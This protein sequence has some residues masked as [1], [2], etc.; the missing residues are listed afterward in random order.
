MRRKNII[1]GVST[2]LCTALVLGLSACGG[3]ANTPQTIPAVNDTVKDTA[4]DGASDASREL[5]AVSEK[6]ASTKQI[7]DDRLIT[8]A[9]SLEDHFKG[10]D[11]VEYKVSIH[12][13][14]ILSED[15]QAQELNQRIMDIWGN[16]PKKTKDEYPYS[17]EQGITI[18]WETHWYGDLLSLVV[19]ED[20]PDVGSAYEVFY[21][22][23]A[24]QK[25]LESPDVLK[26]LSIQPEV[27]EKALLR[28]VAQSFDDYFKDSMVGAPEEVM[29]W[30]AKTLAS[31]KDSLQWLRFYPVSAD[32]LVV[33]ASHCLSS[34]EQWTEEKVDVLLN[35]KITPLHAESHYVTA[36]ASADG[37]TVCFHR[38]EYSDAFQEQYGFEYE[39]AYPVRGCY[40]DYKDMVIELVG[41]DSSPVLFLLTEQ[42]TVEFVRI[43]DSAAYGT[44]VSSGPAYGIGAAGDLD[45]DPPELVGF[46]AGM[47]ETGGTVYIL[48]DNGER[49]DLSIELGSS[50]E[51][52]P[53]DLCA[54]WEASLFE[55]EK[56]TTYN[57][58]ILSYDTIGELVFCDTAADYYVEY[59]GMLDCLG[60]DETGLLYGYTLTGPDGN[61][62]YGTFS[63]LPRYGT[64][65]AGIVG[66]ENL[67]EK[68]GYLEFEEV[69]G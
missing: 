41:P 15:A 1:S 19:I 28:S 54:A 29:L 14:K 18:S 11:G 10:A 55:S 51:R 56:Q 43:L 22:D 35:Q 24:N 61:D 6:D 53:A 8:D 44:M 42:N 63:L 13:P 69:S 34:D 40:G 12:I 49:F 67:F 16:L 7:Y 23:F 38:T 45:P 48:C 65:R 2:V 21:Y 36:D 3:K 60:M 64:L 32:E 20:R 26:A 37:V 9:A 39:K 33:F 58:A 50:R 47:N 17:F 59:Q 31:A 30:R 5:D 4:K 25:K 66:G 52:F 27:L 57:L 46:E 68:T 62:L